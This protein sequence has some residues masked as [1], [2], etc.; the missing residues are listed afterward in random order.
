MKSDLKCCYIRLPSSLHHLAKLEAYTQ[1]TSLQTW[2]ATLIEKE[3]KS[4]GKLDA[5]CHKDSVNE[6]ILQ[7]KENVNLT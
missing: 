4:V 3:L 7:D 5:L 2:V 6:N 1:G